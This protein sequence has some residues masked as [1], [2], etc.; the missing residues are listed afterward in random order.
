VNARKECGKQAR[1]VTNWFKGRRAK[2]EVHKKSRQYNKQQLQLAVN[3]A[4]YEVYIEHGL[5]V[6]KGEE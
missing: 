6:L 4:E 3:R 5:V 1:E 2:R